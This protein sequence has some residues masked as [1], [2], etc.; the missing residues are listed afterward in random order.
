MQKKIFNC[1]NLILILWAKF[2]PILFELQQGLFSDLTNC[3]TYY[4][5]Y[6]GK[7][8]G[9]ELN[10]GKKNV[11]TVT[12]QSKSTQMRIHFLIFFSSISPHNFFCLF[13]TSVVGMISMEYEILTAVKWNFKA[14]FFGKIYSENE[15]TVINTTQFYDT[16]HL[17][18]SR[19]RWPIM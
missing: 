4:C 6:L 1:A 15:W 14:V 16:L 11:V 9:V 10:Q 17:G 5:S 2:M 19:L 13:S 7:P 8:L 3:Q 18:T 12:I